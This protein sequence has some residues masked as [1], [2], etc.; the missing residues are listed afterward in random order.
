MWST[1]ISDIWSLKDALRLLSGVVTE[2][3]RSAETD[4]MNEGL[5]DAPAYKIC[6]LTRISTRLTVDNLTLDRPSTDLEEA[7][8]ESCVVLDLHTHT[9]YL[10]F[11]GRLQERSFSRYVDAVGEYQNTENAAEIQFTLAQA[12]RNINAGSILSD[13]LNIRG[14]VYQTF[15]QPGSISTLMLPSD[16][17]ATR[18]RKVLQLNDYIVFNRKG[19]ESETISS[20]DKNYKW[21]CNARQCRQEIA[22]RK[23]TWPERSRMEFRTGILFIYCWSRNLAK[24][25]FCSEELSISHTTAVDRKN[26]LREVC[27]WRLFQTPTAIGGPDPKTHRKEHNSYI[28]NKR[29]REC[30]CVRVRNYNGLKPVI[31]GALSELDPILTH[32][33]W[34]LYEA[35]TRCILRGRCL[36]GRN[37]DEISNRVEL[38]LIGANIDV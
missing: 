17:I 16:G 23:G 5:R 33:V 11:P 22:L 32:T 12:S 7:A 19:E 25:K 36:S 29:V 34:L 31:G 13:E 1:N 26:L 3:C 10:N 18:Q 6:R 28:P 21:R 2:R 38:L 35:V 8:D 27:A 30:E 14:K 4:R 9:L 20:S 37:E 15:G 24:I